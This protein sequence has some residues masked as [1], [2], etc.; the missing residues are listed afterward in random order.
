MNRLITILFLSS[1]F[2]CVYL[3]ADDTSNP[4]VTH[5][6]PIVIPSGA[7]TQPQPATPTIKQ[8]GGAYEWISDTSNCVQFATGKEG[9][10]LFHIHS[11]GQT[12]TNPPSFCLN[13]RN[14]CDGPAN[15]WWTGRKRVSS[16]GRVD[17][18]YDLT[19]LGN[20]YYTLITA[21]GTVN[22]QA[23]EQT[24]RVHRNNEGKIEVS[25]ENDATLALPGTPTYGTAYTNAG[26]QNLQGQPDLSTYQGIAQARANAM[27][28]YGYPRD[29]H[30]IAGAPPIPGVSEGT[31]WAGGGRF[32][33]TCF[34]SGPLLADAWAT[35]AYNNT[36]RVR[37]FS[38]GGLLQPRI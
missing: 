2:A 3:K 26:Q 16:E 7:I 35:D 10:P 8:K 28:R 17:Y 13:G 23:C 33:A 24:F 37:F 21:R 4:V 20:N 1:L 27:A 22:G 31:G 14:A 30:S 25:V 12:D 19:Q 11:D 9:T 18:T 5:D 32:P 6:G 38:G 34:F 36:Y 15:S 29:G